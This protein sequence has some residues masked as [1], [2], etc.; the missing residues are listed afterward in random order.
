MFWDEQ[1]IVQR[2]AFETLMTV[3]LEA[4]ITKQ[5]SAFTFHKCE[6]SQITPIGLINPNY[7]ND[8]YYAIDEDIVLRPETTMW[9]FAYADHLLNPHNKPKYNLP[10]V[11]Y[12]HWKSFRKEQDKTV[13]NMRLK[14]FYQLEYQII[15][16]KESWNDYYEWIVEHVYW[17]IGRLLWTCTLVPSDRL[18]SYSLKTMDV[19]YN[20]LEVCSI[21]K[22]KDYKATIN[23]QYVDCYVA[24]VAIWT[25]RMVYSFNN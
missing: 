22:R 3:S 10:L 14:E 25:D 6:A 24:E 12:Q 7:T 17:M 15:Y 23:N 1:E 2:N 20:W 16:N 11:V 18:P 8:D 19:E 9:S 21:S 5:N 13:A 4:Y